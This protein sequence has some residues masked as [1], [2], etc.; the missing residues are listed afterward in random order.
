[1]ASRIRSELRELV[2][3]AVDAPVTRFGLS[4]RRFTEEQL[5][6]LGCCRAWHPGLYRQLATC[7]A[8]VS[9]E[10]VCDATWI[11]LEVELGPVP[12]GTK[13]VLA[14]VERWEG[15]P[16]PP[17]DGFSATVDGR[18]LPVA[19]PGER[20]TIEFSLEDPTALPEQ[21]LRLPGMGE[22]HRVSVWLPCLSA[23]SVRSLV[24]DGTFIEPVPKRD[25]LL[26]LGDSI[27][28]G[29]VA[30]DPAL[31]WPALLADRLGL[32]LL[33]QGVGGQVFQ[34]G[35]AAPV[36]QVASPA[37]V[38][39]E[40]GENYRYEPCP[41]SLV[42]RDARAFLG[43]V[44]RA[45]PEADVWVLTPLPHLE[46]VW[47][48]HP[49]SC[50]ADVA[51]IICRWAAR[52]ENMHV[53][54]GTELLDKDRLAELLSDGSDHPGPEGQRQIADRLARLMGAADNEAQVESA[55]SAPEPTEPAALQPAKKARR[56]KK[57]AKRPA[58]S[59]E[60]LPTQLRLL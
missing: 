29:F 8:G 5:R 23:A 17:Y 39:V 51:D 28:Q 25:T 46:D 30:C 60:P 3:G 42:E 40:F 52:H 27:A 45:W 49:G 56:R 11:S 59:I 10:F 36:A 15:A 9:L 58:D 47:P 24:T 14:D 16:K 4:P 20:G 19:L 34:P 41:A 2:H 53:I 33:N 50:F 7:T 21:S 31:A 1:M 12:R 6:A 38:I 54:E 18:H 22:R 43:E 55:P 57:R 35:T 48:T 32:D 44:S 37:H 13:A 26:V